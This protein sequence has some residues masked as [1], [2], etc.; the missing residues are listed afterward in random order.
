MLID[1]LILVIVATLIGG[2]ALFI[3][4]RRKARRWQDSTPVHALTEDEAQ[5]IQQLQ[6]REK[7]L[8][9]VSKRGLRGRPIL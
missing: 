9:K 3:S 6:W 2:L 8:E 7:I 4:L 5:A 1:V